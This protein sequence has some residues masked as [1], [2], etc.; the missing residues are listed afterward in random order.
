MASADRAF[1]ERLKTE[2]RFW[3]RDAPKRDPF[4]P[5]LSSLVGGA[6]AGAPLAR[7]SASQLST[8]GSRVASSVHP[9]SRL[10]GEVV[11]AR[12]NISAARDSVFEQQQRR[13]SRGADGGPDMR[14]QLSAC[15]SVSWRTPSSIR[16]SEPS[17]IA[18][19]KIAEL[20]LRLELEKVLRLQREAE[21]EAMR[22]DALK[23]KQ[24][25]A[26]QKEAA[27]A[28]E[29]RAALRPGSSASGRSGT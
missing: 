6:P 27:M 10:S 14:S 29:T 25:V 16:S 5:T 18:R 1:E 12:S 26:A 22:C 8:G 21:L 9:C 2:A 23:A 3:M 19:N 13:R 17:E 28:A 7:A 24:A 15:T 11:R 4:A 20:Q